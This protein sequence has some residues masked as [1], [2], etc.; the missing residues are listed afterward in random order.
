MPEGPLFSVGANSAKVVTSGGKC[1]Q[2]QVLRLEDKIRDMKSSERED[3]VNEH[4]IMKWKYAANVM[5]SFFFVVSVLYA[6]GIYIKFYVDSAATTNS[7]Y[8][9]PEY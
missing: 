6:L 2:E 4:K 7:Q 3:L 8:T 1:L 5:N 9:I